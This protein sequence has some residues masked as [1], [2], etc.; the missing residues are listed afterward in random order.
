MLFGVG[1]GAGDEA[2]ESG[3]TDERTSAEAAAAAAAARVRRFGMALASSRRRRRPRRPTRV[4]LE[5]VGRIRGPT[6]CA[7]AKPTW[8]NSAQCAEH[9]APGFMSA[10]MVVLE[11]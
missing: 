3:R 5:L 10:H 4:D 1:A 7:L 2:Q 9:F 11:I 6:M 8:L